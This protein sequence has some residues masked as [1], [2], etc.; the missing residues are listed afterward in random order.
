MTADHSKYLVDENPILVLPTLAQ[1]IGL[2]EAIVL[3]QVRYWMSVSEKSRDQRKCINGRWWTYNTYQEWQ[4]NFPWWSIATIQRVIYKLEG[5]G[6]LLSCQPNKSDWDHTKWYSIDYDKVNDAIELFNSTISNSSTCGNQSR[7]A[8]ESL[9]RLTDTSTDTSSLTRT[10]ENS[11]DQTPV[12]QTTTTPLM[13]DVADI[14]GDADLADDIDDED[15]VTVPLDIPVIIGEISQTV[16]A[17]PPSSNDDQEY[18]DKLLSDPALTPDQWAELA[19]QRPMRNKPVPRTEE[20]ARESIRQALGR[21]D[22]RSKTHQTDL[23][24]VREGVRELANVFVNHFGRGPLPKEKAYWIREFDCWA[25]LSLTPRDIESAMATMTRQGL[26]IK[27]PQSV[28]AMAWDG[29]RKQ[30]E[31]SKPYVPPLGARMGVP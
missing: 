10:P 28:T 11:K 13:A 5:Q 12:P 8:E 3:Q 9:I 16:P 30:M 17:D 1:A 25:Q 26:S 21:A 23:S 15:K 4:E 6:L 7:Q 20:Q 19:A 18:W 29:V 2:N 31:N 22:E 14:T 24:F 27:S